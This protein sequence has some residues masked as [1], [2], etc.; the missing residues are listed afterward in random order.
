MNRYYI[1]LFL[2]ISYLFP[3]SIDNFTLLNSNLDNIEVVFEIDNIEFENKSNYVK[4]YDLIK[5]TLINN[6]F[7]Y[8]TYIK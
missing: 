6:E 3:K 5:I 4:I 1:I 8:I 2:I 7:N